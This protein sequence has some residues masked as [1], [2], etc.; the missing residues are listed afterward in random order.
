MPP[1]NPAVNGPYGATLQSVC[2]QGFGGDVVADE[3]QWLPVCWP[4]LRFFHRQ[5]T[6]DESIVFLPDQGM[7]AVLLDVHV[8]VDNPVANANECVPGREVCIVDQAN[9][10][11]WCKSVIGRKRHGFALGLQSLL[12]FSD[13]VFDQDLQG[14]QDAVVFQGTQCAPGKQGEPGIVEEGGLLPGNPV[15]FCLVKVKP[16]VLSPNS[17]RPP[18]PA[19]CGAENEPRQCCFRR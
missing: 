15:D 7:D 13:G 9:A 14:M 2:D 1:G 16:H 10:G 19:R 17:G 12:G 18:V 6:T 11:Q 5:K 3:A 8:V 4:G